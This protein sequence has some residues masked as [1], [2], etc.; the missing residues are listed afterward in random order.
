MYSKLQIYVVIA[1]ALAIAV[2]VKV[3]MAQE[4]ITYDTLFSSNSDTIAHHKVLPVGQVLIDLV[5]IN[6][7]SDQKNLLF[8]QYNSSVD[9]FDLMNQTVIDKI[10]VPLTQVHMVSCGDNSTNV[11]L[12]WVQNAMTPDPAIAG[13]NIVIPTLDESRDHVS[14]SYELMNQNDTKGALGYSFDT[15]KDV[16]GKCLPL[17][18]WHTHDFQKI[19]RPHGW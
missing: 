19:H 7:T 15:F 1:I 5:D 18:I 16:D 3:A 8:Y 10:P 6:D 9:T 13:Y 2:N 12:Y 14:L 11:Y 4:G 17:V